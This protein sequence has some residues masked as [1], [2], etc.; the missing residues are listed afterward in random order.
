MKITLESTT[1]I[2]EIVDL[3]HTTPVQARIWEGQTESGI[4]VVALIPRIAVKNGQDVS[5]FEAELKE[6]RAPS[7]DSILAF[8]LR[9][10][11]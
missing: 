9:M 6:Q 1:K 3:E 7:A 4:S 5:Q 10:I 2:V 8:P 11:L